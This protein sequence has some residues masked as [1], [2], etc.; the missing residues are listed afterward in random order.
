M[1]KTSIIIEMDGDAWCAHRS[2][3]INLQESP[4]GF[5]DNPTRA[6]A[7]LLTEESKSQNA[8]PNMILLRK[9][10]PQRAII[11]IE[12][13]LLSD[14]VS[15]NMSLE[16]P[17]TLVAGQPITSPAIQCANDFVKWLHFAASQNDGGEPKGA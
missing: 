14:G 3:W 5:G 7:A 8:L 2:D 16:P 10:L 4:A 9:T 17:V 12:D 11:T 1:N 13:N 15:V 6:V